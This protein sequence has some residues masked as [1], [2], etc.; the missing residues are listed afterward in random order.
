MQENVSVHEKK[1]HFRILTGLCTRKI[2]I[3]PDK[4]PSHLTL[5]RIKLL[6]CFAGGRNLNVLHDCDHFRD[7]FIRLS[8][9][10]TTEKLLFFC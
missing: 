1:T 5:E 8:H 4:G 2:L 7:H 6:F 9:T 3:F 10:H